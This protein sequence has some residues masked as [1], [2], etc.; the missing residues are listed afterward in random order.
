MSALSIVSLILGILLLGGGIA[1]LAVYGKR[2]IKR[3]SVRP[4]SKKEWAFALLFS[5]LIGAGVL[6]LLVSLFEGHPS[7]KSQGAWLVGPMKGKAVDYGSLYGMSLFGG[8]LFGFSNALMW[9]AFALR[10]YKKGLEKKSLDIVRLFLYGGIVIVFF[11]FLLLGE[12]V[13]PYLTY[14]LF[15]SIVINGNGIGLSKPVG[16][17]GYQ[18]GGLHI[19]FYAICILLGVLISYL[20]SDHGLY[21]EYKKHGILD[22]L[23]LVA[24]PAGVIGARVWYVVGNWDR[25][26]AGQGWA[27]PFEIWNGGLTILGGAAAGVLVGVL[28]L[29]ATKKFVN[30]RLAV[31]IIVPTILLAQA[32]GRFGNFFN[33][34]VYGQTVDATSGFWSFLPSWILAEMSFTNA[35]GSLTTG[36]I[37]VPLFLVEAVLN[38][39]GYFLIVYGVGKGLKRWHSTGALCGVYFLWYGIVRIIMEPMRNANFNMGTDNA[40]SICNSIAYILIGL[41]IIASFHLYDHYKETGRTTLFPIV[42][43]SLSFV[44]LFMPFFQSISVSDKKDGTG[45]LGSYEGFDVI[46][47]KSPYYL[48]SYIFLLLTVLAFAAW[49]V[50]HFAKKEWEI[51]LSLLAS[52]LGLLTGILFFLGS[53][54]VNVGDVGAAYVNLSYGF[55]LTA[56]FSIAAA[57][58]GVLPAYAIYLDKRKRKELGMLPEAKN[59]GANK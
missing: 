28:F 35:G 40:W 37:N 2:Y 12:G 58:L 38:V 13:A 56:L 21:K 16:F 15:N 27:K 36:L 9:L 25:E 32:A 46:F 50:C 23:V 57:L 42:G 4:F 59:G 49:I 17:A 54:Q 39:L 41:L 31:D 53:N 3:A 20:V 22:T 52:G 14:P 19:A 6:F 11:S 44:A 55:V 8:F 45:F 7:W 1:L 5:F 30:M 43:G 10:F 29:R 34:E 18:S 26:F 51:K 24:F 47:G 48:V 33:V